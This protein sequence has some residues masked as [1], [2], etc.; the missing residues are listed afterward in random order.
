MI[1][2][3]SKLVIAVTMS[4]LL[5]TACQAQASNYYTG[6]VES[7]KYT[8]MSGV[9]GEIEEIFVKEGQWVEKGD[10]I[11]RIDSSALEIEKGKQE[12]LLAGAEAELAQIVK[13]ARQEEVNQIYKQIDQQDDQIAI[14]QDQLNHAFDSY[15]KTK[16]LYESGAVSKQKLDDAKL[17]KDNAV[18]KR[19]QAKA[20]KS[21]FQ[22]KLNLVLEGATEE[23]LLAA[24]S[25]VESAKWGV[26]SVLN[27]IED[28]HIQAKHTGTIENIYVSEGEQYQATSKFAEILDL[29]NIKVKI[30]VEELNLHKIG[31]GD[32]VV[33]KVDYD[34]SLEYRGRVEFIAGK[35]EFTPKNLESK[36]NRQEVVYETR[37]RITNKDDR[38]KPGMLVDIYLGDDLNE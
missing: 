12:A 3:Q 8:I 2:K 29:E 20:Q 1:T 25:R 24:Q 7:D 9:S 14:L 23:E 18:S 13:G 15:E 16:N 10:D 30:Y 5:L 26:A 11:A 38:L 33:I 17:L 27:K 31:V 19:D 34:E 21:L 37:I 36:E 22:E 4:L 35:G 6:T 32:D 28:T